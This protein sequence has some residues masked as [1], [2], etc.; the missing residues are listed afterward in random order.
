LGQKLA[1]NETT[2][3]RW[4]RIYRAKGLDGLLNI[5]Q[6]GGKSCSINNTILVALDRRLHTSSGFKSYGEIKQ[7]LKEEYELEIPYKTVYRIVHSKLNAT[8]KVVRPKSQEQNIDKV[9][10]FVKK[11]DLRLSVLTTF[12]KP[13]GVEQTIRFWCTDET[14]IL[15]R[16]IIRRRI[17]AKGVKP[18]MPVQCQYQAYHLYGM[19]EPLTGESFFIEFSNV[20]T[21]CFLLFLEE[22]SKEYPDDIHV[23]QL[24]NASFH[25]AKNLELPDNIILF[26]QQASSPEL[27]RIERVCS[28]IK[29]ELSWSIFSNLDTLKDKV[30]EILKSTDR[31]I[32]A[33]LTGW[34][35]LLPILKSAGF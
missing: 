6:G 22:F 7:W 32:F 28:F 5:E 11:Y 12:Y 30:A 21:T 25:T 13:T 8:V 2:I 35:K 9:T 27:N 18:I 34:D 14:R 33:S 24:D 17:T 31:K 10:D 20:N 29:E 19:V 4:F 16:T 3:G 1:R 15:F 26:F 23:I